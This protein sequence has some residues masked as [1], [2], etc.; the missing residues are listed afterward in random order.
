MIVWVFQTGEPLHCD[1]GNARPLRAMNLANKLVERGHSVSLWS[2]TFFHQEKRHRSVC[3]QKIQINKKLDIRLI[4]SSGYQKNISLMRLWDHFLLAWNL[5]RK[6]REIDLVPDVVFIGYPPIEAAAV[7]A[8]WSKKRNIPTLLDIKDQWP[9]LLV[10]SID[11]RYQWAGRLILSPYFMLS[12][13]TMRRVCG[14]SAMSESFLKWEKAFSGRKSNEWDR[15]VPLTS[16]IYLENQNDLVVASSWW[17]QKGVLDDGAFRLMFVGS[18]SRAFDFEPIFKAAHDLLAKNTNCQ[19]VICGDGEQMLELQEKANPLNNVEIIE[20]IDR[21][22][23][24]I[25]AE[26]SSVVLAPYKNSPDFKASIPNKVIDA[27]MLGMPILT[28][29]QGEVM[30][31]IHHDGIG[32]EYGSLSGK[33]LQ[34][35]IVSLIDDPGKLNGLSINASMAYN[36][37]F[38]FDKVYGGLVNHLEKMA[39]EKA[40]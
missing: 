30:Q 12:R 3:Y 19:F 39:C 25:L 5:Y 10:E 4:P 18:F 21:S 14:I 29:L 6:L 35:C 26:R 15:V 37:Y 34:Q 27:L 24:Q 9:T 23:I 20:W 16:K 33:T 17:D 13:L 28:P 11:Q 1:E 31:L 40:H 36:N 32:L 8:L 7:M 22:R 38:L 2:S